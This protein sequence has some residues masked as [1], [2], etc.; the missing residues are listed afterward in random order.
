MLFIFRVVILFLILFSFRIPVLYNSCVLS[1]LLSL[2][3]YL[4]FRGKIPFGGFTEKY[5]VRIL[6]FL[7]LICIITTAITILH[8]QFD[9]VLV[10]SVV[11]QLFMLTCLV[12]VFPLLTE[13]E[14]H[15][16]FENGINLICHAFALQG[17]IQLT[18][19]FIPAFGS[20]LISIKPERAQ[21]MLLNG[22]FNIYFRGYNLSGSPF[23]EMPAGY[24]ATFILLFRALFIKERTVLRGFRVYLFFFL[25]LV[26]SIM[27]GRTAFIG[28][29]MGVFLSFLLMD[30]PFGAIIKTLK[31]LLAGV[32]LLILVNTFL[33]KP[34][35]RVAIQE[36][37]LPF[38]FEAF[39]NYERTGKFRTSSTDVM[40]HDH[41]YMLPEETF[42]RGEGRYRSRDGYYGD[43]DAGYMRSVLYGGLGFTILLMIYQSFYFVAPLTLARRERT[44][45]GR[46]DFLCFL[47]LFIHLFILEYK[48]NTIGLQQIMQVL[49]LF[50][51][52][53][54]LLDYSSPYGRIYHKKY[55]SG[56]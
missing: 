52:M 40:L 30:N 36:H 55:L 27:S 8:M 34:S 10:K 35:Q 41:Y 44:P 5:V 29:L 2:G 23:F 45:S 26:G 56:I 50:I 14:E 28:L 49:L 47:A 33:L 16:G 38:A 31:V 7:S 32:I 48:A 51:G 25:F 13:G 22:P 46:A 18:A 6:G 3:Y 53:S 11:L 12:F 4:V 1:I 21:D 43:T 20:F 17:L 54:Y 24:G 37:V 15:H 9:Y 19:F 39:Y 42:I